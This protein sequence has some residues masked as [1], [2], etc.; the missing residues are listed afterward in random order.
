MRFGVLRGLESIGSG[1][2][3]QIDGFSGQTEP[4]GIIFIVL[5]HDIGH[6]GVVFSGLMLLSEDPKTLREG[7]EGPGTL[8]ESPV[9]LVAT[10]PHQS[11]LVCT[12]HNLSH[13]VWTPVAFTAVPWATIP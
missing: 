6:F 4:Y 7:P 9:R 3:I 11:Q 2:G 8:W 1:C 5:F 10:S 13:F 12:C